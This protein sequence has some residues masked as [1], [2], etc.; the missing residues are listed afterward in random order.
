VVPAL[1]RRI[2][3]KSDLATTCWKGHCWLLRLST[4][5]MVHVSRQASTPVVP[6]ARKSSR[7]CLECRCRVCANPQ[8]VLLAAFSC[9][10]SNYYPLLYR[11]S[12]L[13]LLCANE[14]SSAQRTS[15]VLPRTCR[16][17]AGK[18][19]GKVAGQ[20]ATTHLRKLS[21]CQDVIAPLS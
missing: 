2:R 14:T 13:R 4:K 5:R 19:Q 12:M 11:S 18:R 9:P 15:R 1:F 16:Q 6:G 21:C 7:F 20:V 8:V 3:P 10:L 17:Y